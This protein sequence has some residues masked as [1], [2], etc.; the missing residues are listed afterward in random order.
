V[1]KLLYSYTSSGN[2]N[3]SIT[4]ADLVVSRVVVKSRET[5]GG[6]TFDITQITDGAGHKLGT[7][8]E[9]ETGG[10]F[11]YKDVKRYTARGAERDSYLPFFGGGPS[12]VRLSDC[13]L[14]LT[15]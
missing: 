6:G 3:L 4:A 14:C 7:I 5:A 13:A 11:V 1:R 12:V 9:G 8:E 15:W 10:Q 2:L